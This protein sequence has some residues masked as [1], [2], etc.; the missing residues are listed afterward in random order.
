[1]NKPPWVKNR[2]VSMDVGDYTYSTYACENEGHRGG[3]ELCVICEPDRRKELRRLLR[4][5][6]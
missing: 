3:W 2:S 5:L 1:M 4:K 6:Q